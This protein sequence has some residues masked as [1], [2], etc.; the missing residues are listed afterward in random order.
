MSGV[1]FITDEKE[2][3]TGVFFNHETISKINA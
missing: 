3:K 2:K 1:Q